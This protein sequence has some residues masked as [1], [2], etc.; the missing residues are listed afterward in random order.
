MMADWLNGWLKPQFLERL[1]VALGHFVWQAAIIGGLAAIVSRVLTAN[2]PRLRYTTQLVCLL[3]MATCI[4][5]TVARNGAH[6]RMTSLAVEE[7]PVGVSVM[8]PAGENTG[9]TWLPAATSADNN[10]V[11]AQRVVPATAANET[12][13]TVIPATTSQRKQTPIAWYVVAAWAAGVAAMALR[14]VLAFAGAW[15]LSQNAGP[16]TQPS[17]LASFD[18]VA[19]ALRIRVRPR[20]AWCGRVA[21]PVV[22]G[23]LRPV[24]LL[25]PSLLSGLEPTQLEALLAHELV[26]VRRLDPIVHS[27]QRM[28]ECALFFHPAVWYVSRLVSRERE[29]CCDDAVVRAGTEPLLYA[30]ALVRMGELCQRPS[31]LSLAA[32][33]NSKTEFRHRIL[34]L[35]QPERNARGGGALIAMGM[36]LLALGVTHAPAA[37]L[38][39]SEQDSAL[40]HPDGLIAVLGEDRAR[41]WGMSQAMALTPDEERVFLT[42]SLGFVS[43][44]DTTTLKRVSQFRAHKHRCLDL[45][46]LDSG[47]KLVTISTDGTAALWDVTEPNPRELD[48]LDLMSKTEAWLSM[49]ASHTGDRLVVRA[50]TTV[51]QSSLDQMVVLKVEGQRFAA[52]IELPKTAADAWHFTIS[53]DGRWL[54]TCETRQG[55]VQQVDVGD[56]LRFGRPPVSL[57]IRD[58]DTPKQRVVSKTD[59]MSVE[60]LQFTPNGR[61]WAHDPDFLSREKAKRHSWHLTANGELIDHKTAPPSGGTFR[62]HAF[63]LDGEHVAV[64][65]GD[66]LVVTKISDNH[67]LAELKSGNYS[68]CCF[69][70]DRSLIVTSSPILQRWNWKE[71]GYQQEAL[72]TG[73][74]ASVTGLMYDP[75]TNSLLSAGDDTLREWKLAELQ[76]DEP[77]VSEPIPF[78]DIHKMRLWPQGKGFLLLRWGKSNVVQGVRRAGP[79]MLTRFKIDLGDDYKQAAWSAALHPTKRLLATGHWDHSIRIWDIAGGRPKLLKKWKA[80]SGHVCEVAFDPRGRLLS[81]GWDRQT[82]RWTIPDDLADAEPT[83]ETLCR[84]VDIVRSVVASPDGRY[85]ASGGEDGQILLWDNKSPGKV[86]SLMQPD[87]PAPSRNSNTSRTPNSLQFSSDGAR[88]LSSDGQG[89][90]TIW[91][92]SDGSIVKGWQLAGPVKSTQFLA[93]ESI[94]ATANNDGTVF[95]LEA[96]ERN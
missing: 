48:R 30:D 6:P 67:V 92:T 4:P 69:L 25:P 89:R 87:D 27:L 50:H 47:R 49:S 72:P 42:E 76:P 83:S 18:F 60:R 3:G 59:V 64:G 10:R 23:V 68:N 70:K 36:L 55:D 39:D 56:G 46:M 17:V 73:H 93:D 33:G 24:I 95:L 61:L 7:A 53:R 80:H 20:L 5:L 90:V 94:I 43:A 65:Q 66:Q 91:K 75:R 96:P 34:R 8:T 82:I 78:D 41:H 45:A 81:A 44:F 37:L 1:A 22:V 84:H 31:P 32:S 13:V 63:S 85:V 15:R 62:R 9:L 58:L 74:H 2:S 35:I 38:E 79:K 19:H 21:V 77:P 57:T 16:V 14:L 88:L 52:P 11:G 29:L 26:H 71:N 86:R 54:V 12:A 51:G 28:I 40:G